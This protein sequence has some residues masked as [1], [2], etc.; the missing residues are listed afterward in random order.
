[1][2]LFSNPIILILIQLAVFLFFIFLHLLLFF[3]QQR[4]INKTQTKK[5]NVEIIRLHSKFLHLV[6][7]TIGLK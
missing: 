2:V 7:V 5:G 1:M 4:L 3:S 6:S